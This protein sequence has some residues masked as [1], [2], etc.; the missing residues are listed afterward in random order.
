MEIKEACNIFQITQEDTELTI[1]KK[2]RELIKKWHPDVYSKADICEK[3][4][5]EQMTKK[6]NNAREIIFEYIEIYG[7]YDLLNI[8]FTQA[9]NVDNDNE[10]YT[11][12]NGI[13]KRSVEG[14]FW[15]SVNEKFKSFVERLEHSEDYYECDYSKT[16]FE[17]GSG[18][19]LEAYSLH[20]M[21]LLLIRKLNLF[22]YSMPDK[23]INKKSGKHILTVTAKMVDSEILA[24]YSIGDD[25]YLSLDFDGLGRGR[26]S[27][28]DDLNRQIAYVE[29]DS[30][31]YDAVIFPLCEFGV[32]EYEKTVIKS[33]KPLKVNV[34]F[35]KTGKG[36]DYTIVKERLSNFHNFIGRYIKCTI[37]SETKTFFSLLNKHLDCN[38][39]IKEIKSLPNGL[40]KCYARYYFSDRCHAKCGTIDILQTCI[41]VKILDEIT[42]AC[43]G[44]DTCSNKFFNEFPRGKKYFLIENKCT[45]IYLKFD[46]AKGRSMKMF[47][48]PK[49][50]LITN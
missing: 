21:S 18:F 36:C 31:Y 15:D 8:I 45:D 10:K 42:A 12:K 3:N 22:Y 48:Y 9:E 24:N 30:D 40:G 35:K 4:Q 49:T 50:T 13:N 25:V 27:I 2:Y 1:K 5:A 26:Y 33:I 20:R 37:D 28:R 23:I 41:D 14:P 6:I 7:L 46:Y 19:S 11:E 34:I 16:D 38:F 29:L 47:F 43:I 39:K 44:L 17:N 32:L